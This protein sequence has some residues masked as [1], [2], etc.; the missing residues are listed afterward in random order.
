MGFGPKGGRSLVEHRGN[1]YV[2]TYIRPSVRPSARP[3]LPPEAPQRGGDRWTDGRTYVRTDVQIPPILQ[4]FVS[5]GS[6]RSRCPKRNMERKTL[7]C[8][9]MI[10]HSQLTSANL[11]TSCLPPLDDR[12]FKCLQRCSLRAIPGRHDGSEWFKLHP[13]TLFCLNMTS[14]TQLTFANSAPNCLTQ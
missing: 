7:T 14:H 4:D 1:L 3:S 6:L 8:V 9:Y 12:S 13:L 5:S 2:R 10:S 11:G